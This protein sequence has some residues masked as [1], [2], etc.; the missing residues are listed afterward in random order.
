MID[1]PVSAANIFP[2]G[3][4]VPREVISSGHNLTQPQE[5]VPATAGAGGTE[6]VARIEQFRAEMFQWQ[7]KA[8]PQTES[9]TVHDAQKALKETSEHALIEISRL[10]ASSILFNIGVTAAESASSSIKTLLEK[11]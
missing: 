11:Q 4:E 9:L 7:T 8:A 5:I 1:L 6:L 10:N 3:H 2:Q